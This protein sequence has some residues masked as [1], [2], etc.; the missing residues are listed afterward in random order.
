MRSVDE[1]YFDCVDKALKLD[2]GKLIGLNE[3]AAQFREGVDR[4][5]EFNQR[6]Q[7]FSKH[8]STP[9]TIIQASLDTLNLQNQPASQPIVKR[10]LKASANMSR[11]STALLWLARESKSPIEQSPVDTQLLCQQVIDDHRYLLKNRDMTIQANITANTLFIE[12]ELFSIVL[13]NLLRNAFQ[14]SSDGCIYVSI[15]NHGLQITNPVKMGNGDKTA[16]STSGF[17]LGLQLVERICLKLDWQF[18]FNEEGDRAVVS[19][20]WYQE[21]V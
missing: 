15:S 2:A 6:E 1:R 8:A 11:L 3:I 18:S 16:L 14:H 7:Q 4:I 17:G 5:Q 20:F 19:V 10:A 13:S 9:L 12:S 21:E